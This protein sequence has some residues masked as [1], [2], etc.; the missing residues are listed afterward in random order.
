VAGR[1]VFQ[2]AERAALALAEAAT[3]IADRPDPVSDDVWDEAARRYTD[4]QLAALVV[5]IA[6]I[7]AENRANV[8]TRQITGEW[9]DQIARHAAKH[10]AHAA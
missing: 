5:A 10:A 2:R 8:V 1:A 7:N 6:A 9:T 4:G 3:R